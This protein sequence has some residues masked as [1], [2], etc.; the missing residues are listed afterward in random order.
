MSFAARLEQAQQH[1]I[2]VRDA[3]RR[4]GWAAEL[5]GQGQLPDLLRTNLRRV[6]TPVRWMS[7]I[8]AVR[9][10]P[11]SRFLVF[12]DAKAGKKYLETGNHDIEIS[13]LESAERWLTFAGDNCRYYFVFSDGGVIK[14]DRIREIGELGN[15]RGNGSGT[16]FLLFPVDACTPFDGVFGPVIPDHLSGTD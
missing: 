12:V 5:F 15:Y 3:L 10:Y 13:A 9:P 6:D 2:D 4:R 8:I 16:P 14:P 11:E 7:D 1:E